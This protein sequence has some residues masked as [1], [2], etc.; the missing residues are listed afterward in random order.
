MQ[1]RIGH[2]W[3]PAASFL[4]AI[5]LSVL[6]GPALPAQSLRPAQEQ[7]GSKNVGLTSI[8]ADLQ[9]QNGFAFVAGN[10]GTISVKNIKVCYEVCPCKTVSL[11]LKLT[12]SAT[13]VVVCPVDPADPLILQTEH[14]PLVV[15]LR[16]IKRPSLPGADVVKEICVDLEDIGNL[17]GGN[18]KADLDAAIAAWKAA[19]PACKVIDIGFVGGSR[20]SENG[21]TVV[22][23]AEVTCNE[24]PDKKDS[25]GAGGHITAADL[26]KGSGESKMK[27]TGKGCPKK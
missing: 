15:L 25:G 22:V 6:S 10:T 9:M 1:K 17:S 7:T 24:E 2:W 18:V 23:T 12:L 4:L 11:E 14:V 5:M 21:F 19:N 3:V 27:F 26:K 16:T 8:K 13:L 20:A